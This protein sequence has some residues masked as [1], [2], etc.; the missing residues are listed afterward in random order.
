MNDGSVPW[1]VRKYFWSPCQK[2]QHGRKP[3]KLALQIIKIIAITIQIYNFGKVSQDNVEFKSDMRKSVWRIV[4]PSGGNPSFPESPFTSTITTKSEFYKQIFLFR[5]GV[6]TLRTDS[7]AE[8][9]GISNVTILLQQLEG[10]FESYTLTNFTPGEEFSTKI[11]TTE[12]D[13]ELDLILHEIV[14]MRVDLN[15]SHHNEVVNKRTKRDYALSYMLKIDNSD[16]SGLADVVLNQTMTGV[17]DREAISASPI[18]LLDFLVLVVSILSTMLVIRSLFRAQL[19][20]LQ[21]SSWYMQKFNEQATLSDC[22]EFVDGWYILMLVS[23]VFVIIGTGLKLDV[24]T[25]Q[26]PSVDDFQISCIFLGLGALLC[27][28]GILRYLGYF[29]GYNILVLTLSHAMPKVFKFLTCALTL[30]FGYVVCG[31]LVLGPF[32][33]KFRNPIITSQTLFSLLNGD[34][35]FATFRMLEP[36]GPSFFSQIY[37]Y[38]FICL[39][40][41][42]V[43]SLFISV[44]MDSYETIKK[45]NGH[46]LH[47][48]GIQKALDAST[49][50]E[51]SCPGDPQSFSFNNCFCVASADSQASD[52][53]PLLSATDE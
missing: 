26:L 18:I 6:H 43:L 33:S 8:I 41:Y 24:Q 22:N 5:K 31:W 30:Y 10:P 16:H 4:N 11:P 48:R 35:M 29:R 19:L 42:T 45:N 27:Y 36:G 37:L 40:I 2:W 34:D 25:R 28:S 44:V 17:D 47:S 21:F 13:I 38:S 12:A 15:I 49:S 50:E 20:R 32:N 52:D 23:D 39:F 46:R 53:Q 14:V 7:L 3:F 51:D 9:S 1:K